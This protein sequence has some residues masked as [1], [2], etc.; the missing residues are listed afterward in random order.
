M[1]SP[2]HDK[3]H[4]TTCKRSA[5][6]SFLAIHLLTIGIDFSLCKAAGQDTSMDRQTYH[7]PFQVSN[8]CLTQA[9]CGVLVLDGSNFL[10]Q[11]IPS[12]KARV[13]QLQS[14]MAAGSIT[15]DRHQPRLQVV[16]GSGDDTF[17]VLSLFT[18]LLLL[19][20]SG[21]WQHH[22]TGTCR[23]FSLQR[24]CLYSWFSLPHTVTCS[25]STLD[26]HWWF[27]FYSTK[28]N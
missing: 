27:L 15:L 8:S 9:N 5:C 17:F 19:R 7:Q 10:G 28:K 2:E 13:Q 4:P 3:T 6:L 14:A 16:R 11:G 25:N 1:P 21:F 24:D 20:D 12:S 22:L 23:S 26:R 18:V